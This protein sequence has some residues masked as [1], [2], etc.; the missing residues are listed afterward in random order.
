[1]HISVAQK[2]YISPDHFYTF[3]RS[4]PRNI[5]LFVHIALHTDKFLEYQKELFQDFISSVTE[6]LSNEEIVL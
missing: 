3:E 2:A 5:Q 4:F 6:L 1:M